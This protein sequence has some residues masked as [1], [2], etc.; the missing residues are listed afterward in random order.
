MADGGHV[1]S[2][3]LQRGA[4]LAVTQGGVARRAQAA[5]AA[6]EVVALVG[7]GPGQLQALV[8]IWK[9]QAGCRG[10]LRARRSL[11][12]FPRIQPPQ[13]CP[14]LGYPGLLSHSSLHCSEASTFPWVR[15]RPSYL[16]SFFS[17]P[18]SSWAPWQGRAEV[19]GDRAGIQAPGEHAISAG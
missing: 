17:P 6:L 8:D 2:A 15:V 10:G 18:S 13:A 4:D 16:L 19:W 11:P 12:A 9:A 14:L 1:L 7:A 3:P 5:V